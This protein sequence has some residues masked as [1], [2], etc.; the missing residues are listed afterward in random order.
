MLYKLTI[1]GVFFILFTLTILK[2]GMTTS[3]AH[4]TMISINIVLN[5]DINFIN[6]GYLLN[7]SANTF[8]C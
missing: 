3:Q 1:S 8:S 5:D 2:L 4:V 7:K 6:S